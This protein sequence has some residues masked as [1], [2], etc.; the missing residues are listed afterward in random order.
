MCYAETNESSPSTTEE[1]QT[2]SE[3]QLDQPI[4]DFKQKVICWFINLC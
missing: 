1:K 2:V 3:D 4:E